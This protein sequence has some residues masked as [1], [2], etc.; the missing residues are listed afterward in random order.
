MYIL[1]DIAEEFVREFHKNLTQGH[2]GA[3]ALVVRLQEE[4]IIYGI[5]GIAR[6]VISKCLDCQRNKS[7]RH[8]LYGML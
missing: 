7:V 1:K 4:Y 3:I 2:N 8:R 5:W 6:K